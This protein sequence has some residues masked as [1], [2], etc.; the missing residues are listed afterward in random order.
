MVDRN[1]TYAQRFYDAALDYFEQGQYGKAL[2]HIQKAIEKSPNNPDFHSTRGIFLHKMNDMPGAA[3]AYREALKIS[4]SHVFSHYN[5][6]LILMK[7]GKTMDAIH[8]WEAVIRFHPQ[9]V[10]ATFNI[11]VALNHIGRR[12]DAMTFYERVLSLKNDHVQ[13]HQNLGLLYRD[14]RQYAKAKHHLR[15]LKELD[16]TYSEVVNAELLK[17]D[18]QEFLEA[19]MKNDQSGIA[20]Q[21]AARGDSPADRISR[22]LMAMINGEFQVALDLADSVLKE[23]PGEVQARLVRG[24]TWLAMNK[25]NDAIAE[26]MG[27][28]AADPTCAD[29]YFQLGNI[30]LG[31]NELEKA[32]DH[33][34]RVKAIN[35]DFPTIEENIV[36]LRAQIASAQRKN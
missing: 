36:N 11:A 6:G 17:V 1:A 10:D 21:V 30:F 19:T 24:Q 27:I 2:E 5:L 18:E 25:Q 7:L 9:D 8:E 12:K 16:A 14:E 23:I 13:T 34:E 29:A 20:K 32:L 35:R 28:V 31:M 3:G 4:P 22:A 15:K 33:F 26:F